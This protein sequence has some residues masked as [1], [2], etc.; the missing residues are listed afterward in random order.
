VIITAIDENG[1][2]SFCE[3]NIITDFS[4][5]IDDFSLDQ[6]ITLFPNPTK[7]NITLQN[8][9]DITL[10]EVIIYDSI[11]RIINSQQIDNTTVDTQISLENHP[12]GIYFVRI[13]SENTNVV[14]RIIKQ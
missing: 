14:R 4:L 1:N 5:D 13:N 7:G 9:N 10:S 12:D 3:F 11:G 2:E 8:N 6:S